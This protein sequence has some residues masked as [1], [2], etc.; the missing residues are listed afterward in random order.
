MVRAS[1]C[2][3]DVSAT[4]PRGHRGVRIR[5]VLEKPRQLLP[6]LGG[7]NETETNIATAL[8]SPFYWTRYNSTYFLIDNST[9]EHL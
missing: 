7:D 2:A 5:R 3:V 4:V 6:R 1:A 9:N 8:D